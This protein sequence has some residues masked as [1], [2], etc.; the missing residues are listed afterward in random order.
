MLKHRD[1]EATPFPEAAA[2][3]VAASHRCG[4]SVPGGTWVGQTQPEEGR[5]PLLEKEHEDWP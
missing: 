1:D 4:S 3:V 2:S 5:E